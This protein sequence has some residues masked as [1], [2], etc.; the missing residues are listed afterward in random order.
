[1]RTLGRWLSRI[2]S[3]ATWVMIFVVCGAWVFSM[4]A[5]DLYWFSYDKFFIGDAIAGDGP[6]TVA[7][8]RTFN[9][10]FA[11]RWFATLRRKENG[12]FLTYAPNSDGHPC[13]ARGEEYVYPD[14]EPGDPGTLARWFDNPKCVQDLK[15]GS[16]YV[17]IF[18]EWD[19][20]RTRTFKISS[21]VFTVSAGGPARSEPPT[22]VI[23]RPRI[24]S[25]TRRAPGLPWPLSGIF[26]RR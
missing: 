22:V 16:Y 23:V 14:Y 20:L 13:R 9:R 6:P 10:E 19:F 12:T 18:L 2:F 21:N 15:P 25:P 4:A 1:M 11:L 8:D 24:V 5:P 3:I 26:G 7:L 17:E